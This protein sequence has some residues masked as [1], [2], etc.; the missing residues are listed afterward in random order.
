MFF[1]T[2]NI[3]EFSQKTRYLSPEEVGVYVLFRDYYMHEEKP[4]QSN[5]IALAL[6]TQCKASMDRVLALF[7][8]ETEAGWVCDEFET[9]IAEYRA[10]S[11][12]K[13]EG[14][15]NRWKKAKVD[16]SAKHE[17]CNSNGSAMHIHSTSNG[18]G[19]LTNNQEPKTKNQKE[20]EEKEKE[21]VAIAPDVDADA[22]PDLVADA[23]SSLEAKKGKAEAKATRFDLEELPFDW[24]LDAFEIQRELDAYKLFEG[25]GDYWVNVT[26]NKG[27][28]VDWKRTWRNYLRDFPDW[29]RDNYLREGRPMFNGEPYRVPIDPNGSVAAYKAME[30]AARQNAHKEDDLIAFAESRVNYLRHE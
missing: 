12:K 22:S 16:A 25:F 14:A 29:K 7:F 27:K 30:E 9:A 1:F 18:S 8:R 10:Q 20:K 11:D 19:L 21:P 23:P 15:K 2:H 28:K 3:G 5:W 6:P 24:F 4:L 26:G 17:Q 13:R